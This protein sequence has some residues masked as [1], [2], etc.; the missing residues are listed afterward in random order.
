MNNILNYPVSS[1]LQIVLIN[2]LRPANPPEIRGGPDDHWPYHTIL[3]L[4]GKVRNASENTTQQGRE[5]PA[6]PG[7]C[8]I[9]CFGSRYFP[10]FAVSFLF[11]CAFWQNVFVP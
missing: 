9:A 8:F 1:N 5:Q 7:L 6:F 10:L 11:L 3:K 4:T 2:C